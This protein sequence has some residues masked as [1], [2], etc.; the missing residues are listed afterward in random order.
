MTAEKYNLI[1]LKEIAAFANSDMTELSPEILV[2]DSLKLPQGMSRTPLRI[3]SLIMLLCTSG[4]GR[5]CIDL[6]KYKVERNTIVS[7]N[8]RNYVSI[9][10]FSDDLRFTVL[11]CTHRVVEEVLPKLT[12][13]LPLVIH[14][15]HQPAKKITDEEAER[16]M[17]YVMLIKEHMDNPPTQFRA[18]KVYCLL[19]ATLFELMEISCQQNESKRI[20]SSR[21]EE[22]MVKFILCVLENFTRHRQ[23]NYYANKLCI[24]S[25]HLSA[26]VKETSGHTAGEWIENHV[27]R[28]AK[29]L[30]RTTDLT[31]QEISTRL[32]FANQSFFGKYF[33]H[34]TGVSPSEF[35]QQN[36]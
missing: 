3:D 30:L 26:V 23:V 36:M 21:K 4:E 32:N 28:E 27:V 12:A 9:E 8:P 2:I 19:Q 25:K 35:R 5:V 33:K 18:P 7:I 16:L 15:R 14:N 13:L 10:D 34:L 20:S 17:K 1:S 24:T 31:I 29:M 11:V 22:I 6:E